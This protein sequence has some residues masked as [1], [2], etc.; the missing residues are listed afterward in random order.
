M[1]IGI[2]GKPNA[3]KSTFLAAATLKDVEIASYPFTTIRPNDAIA[4]ATAKCPCKELNV[5]CSPQNSKCKDGIR[6]IPVRLMDVAGLVPGAHKGK[7]RGVEFLNDLAQASALIHVI[8]ISGSTDSEGK[9]VSPGSHDPIHDIEFLEKEIDYWML[10]ILKKGW[11]QITMKMRQKKEKPEVILHK[12]L[13]GLG[14][15][16]DGV[17]ESLLDTPVSPESSDQELMDFVENLRK[18]SKPIL[19]AANKIDVPGAG[20]NYEHLREVGVDLVPTSAESELA[21]RKAAEKGLVEYSPGDS[22]FGVT[23]EIEEKQR[24]A[25]EFLKENV[26]EKWGGTGVQKAIDRTV[27]SLLGM[28]VVYPVANIGKMTDQ[29][30]NVLPDAHLVEK[31]TTLKELAAKVHTAM[32]DKFVGGMNR[33]RRKLGADYEL[34]D[35][36]VVEILFRD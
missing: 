35:G 32:A 20:K 5:T 23:G 25:L 21:L 31:G 30:G 27:Y 9:M 1:L 16:V 28:I 7:G 29:K 13:S 36:D 11:P 8:D 2:V 22:S 10:G 18:R 34:K 4:Y 17:K 6:L 15:T 33:E 12:Q 19:I 3:G 14:I 24:K 26:L